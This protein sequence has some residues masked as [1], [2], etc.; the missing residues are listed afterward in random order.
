MNRNKRAVKA[1]A[2]GLAVLMA[3]NACFGNTVYAANQEKEE[4]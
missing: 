1:A 3:G 4:K 2:A